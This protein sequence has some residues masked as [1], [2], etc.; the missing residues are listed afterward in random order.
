MHGSAEKPRLSVHR[1][2]KYVYLQAIDD[3]TGK[4]I[5]S[6][7]D[8]ELRRSGSNKETKTA[9]ASVAAQEIAKLLKAAK[10]TELVFDRGAYKYHGRVRAVAEQLRE[11]GMK[12]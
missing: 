11:Q 6:A 4:T 1:T 9:T 12:V 3:T 7:S 5:A 2:N 10:V 8:V